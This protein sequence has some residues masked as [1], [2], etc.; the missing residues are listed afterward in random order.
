MEPATNVEMLLNEAAELIAKGKEPD[1]VKEKLAA[2]GLDENAISSILHQIKSKRF[3]IRRK[4]GFLLGLIGS[5]LL[6]VGFILTVVF[7]HAGISIHFVMYSMTSIGALLLVLGL[8]EVL[9]W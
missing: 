4:R 5:L 1:F 8:V 7:F 9:G 3:L 6:F 2:Y